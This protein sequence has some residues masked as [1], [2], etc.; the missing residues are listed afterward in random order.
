MVHVTLPG[1]DRTYTYADYLLW[2]EEERMEIIDGVPY[3]QA[4]PSRLHQE[5][6]SELHRQIANYL[7][8][9]KCKVYPAP[10]HVVLNLEQENQ[11]E[12]DSQNVF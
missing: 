5:I 10:F 8:G 3:L 2:S 7:V 1:K 4:T 12:E 9:E 11:K 6:L